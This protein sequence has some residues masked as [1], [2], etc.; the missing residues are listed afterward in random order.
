M[1]T[2]MQREGVKYT[3]HHIGIPTEKQLDG[4]RYAAKV[5]MYT[6]DDLTGPVPV[7]WHRF[8]PN[9]PLHPLIRKE[10]HV[11]YRVSS[12]AAAIEGHTVLLGP[13]EPIDGYHVAIVDNAGMPVEFIETSLSDA[14]I[15]GRARTGQHASIYKL[16][17]A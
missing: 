11:A 17:P 1:T 8:E 2:A 13:Y 7:Q 4:E 15:W 12:L 5:G 3:L 14:E 9:S 10:P 6:T 16:V